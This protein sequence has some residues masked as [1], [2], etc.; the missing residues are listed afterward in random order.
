MTDNS[1]MSSFRPKTPVGTIRLFRG[2][3]PESAPTT[4]RDDV[5]PLAEHLVLLRTAAATPLTDLSP[6]VRAAYTAVTQRVKRTIGTDG[7]QALYDQATQA[8]ASLPSF[9]LGT[10]GAYFKGCA[11]ETNLTPHG[12]SVQA[13]NALPRPGDDLC[14]HPVYLAEVQDGAYKFK[15]LHTARAGLSAT[16]YVFVPV[17]FQGFA[18]PERDWLARRVDTFLIYEVNEDGTEYTEVRKEPPRRTRALPAPGTALA[19]APAA[20]SYVFL[21]SVL[22]VVVLLVLLALRMSGVR[23]FRPPEE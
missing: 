7:Y 11:I 6:D 19:P 17:G 2:D 9:R 4:P 12:C 16:A 10:V 18:Q 23:F 13:V 15:A 5:D 14:T 3:T 8:F 22:A 20:W 21:L 1:K